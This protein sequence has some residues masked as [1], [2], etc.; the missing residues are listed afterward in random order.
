MYT[1]HYQRIAQ[2]ALIAG[3]ALLYLLPALVAYINRRKHAGAIMLLNLSFG[4]TF[5]GW[6]LAL[7]LACM[8]DNVAQASTPKPQALVFAGPSG[9]EDRDM[10][11]TSRE[12]WN[13]QTK[14]T[15]VASGRLSLGEGPEAT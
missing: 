11:K 4:W 1:A 14:H 5:L 2:V 8:P 6:V 12:E 10:N 7:L 13:A 9:K 15:F 3:L